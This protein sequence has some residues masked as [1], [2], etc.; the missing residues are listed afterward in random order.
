MPWQPATQDVVVVGLLQD[1]GRAFELCLRAEE[2]LGGPEGW[3]SIG[4]MCVCQEGEIVVAW[5]GMTM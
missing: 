3:N 4:R 5:R 2:G 1:T